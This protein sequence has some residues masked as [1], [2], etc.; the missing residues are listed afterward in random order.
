MKTILVHLPAYR[1]PELIPTIE[2]CLANAKYPKRIHFGICRQFN[3]EDGFDNVDKYRD[4]KGF[5]VM[6]VPFQDAK[7]LP[8]AR[9]RINEDLL[10][11]E[12]Y[13]LQLDSHH[14][15]VKDWDKTLID[16]HKGLKKKGIK[17]PLIGGYLPQY[18]PDTD[19]DG[20][21]DCPWQ[22]QFACFYPHGTIFIRP[23]MLPHWKDLNEP[24]LAR[25]LSGHFCFGESQWARDVLHDPDIFFSGEELNLSVRSFTHGYDIF[26]SH[27]LVIFHATM[28]EE[29]DGILVWDDKNK[30]GED[31]WSQ[32]ISARAK[33]RQLLYDE[34]NGF[35]IKPEYGLGTERTVQDYEK[36]AGIKFK[37][38]QIQQWTVENHYPPNP[39]NS[40]WKTS[41]YHLVTIDR[42]MLPEDDYTSILIAFD[43]EDGN[44]LNSNSI[45]GP[46]LEAFI[47]GKSIHY[48]EFFIHD[49]D[50]KPV[51]MVAWAVSESRGWAER[52]E[53]QIIR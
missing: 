10:D 14:R 23:G 28:R 25:F 5:K 17:K 41:F 22:A 52:H 30:N 4:R 2:S 29:R 46:Q 21:A 37:E 24:P 27:K 9:A 13:V 51:R 12:D 43:D 38:K 1:E 11:D 26:H 44:A 47:N 49:N 39:V 15:F 20:R 19:P 40:E 53:E 7:G 33:I 31:W 48:E 16:M 42:H 32:Q 18:S 34:D 35:D 8:W 36:F 50:V 6:D 45:S 3:P